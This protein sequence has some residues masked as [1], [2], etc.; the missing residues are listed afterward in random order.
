VPPSPSM[1]LFSRC[2]Y[3]TLP[4]APTAK[5]DPTSCRR[6][7]QPCQHAKRVQ[8]SNK[9][10]R[11]N[12]GKASRTSFNKGNFVLIRTADLYV[13]CVTSSCCTNTKF[14]RS[15]FPSSTRLR[16]QAKGGGGEG[17]AQRRRRRHQ[18]LLVPR[19]G[20]ALR[21]D[22]GHQSGLLLLRRGFRHRL[23]EGLG[24]L[25]VYTAQGV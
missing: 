20:G 14:Q 5:L 22:L 17:A 21:Q 15:A 3:A 4:T 6:F 24:A 23:P 2:R 12:N 11:P 7:R 9:S 25:K 10:I 19:V 18:L 16:I 1:D 13:C 8:V